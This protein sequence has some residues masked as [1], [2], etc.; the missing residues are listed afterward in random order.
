M[1]SREKTV[2]G[3]CNAQFLPERFPGLFDCLFVNSLCFSL[4]VVV[5]ENIQAPTH[6][7]VTS[8]HR[9]IVLAFA[10][11][12]LVAAATH[13]NDGASE[14]DENNYIYQWTTTTSTKT[15]TTIRTSL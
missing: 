12:K 13:D 7:V 2:L 3:I 14:N 5:V 15:I 11:S 10:C 9:H 4:F 6:L 8:K 1:F